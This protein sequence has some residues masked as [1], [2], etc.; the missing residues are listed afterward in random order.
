[1][2][3][4]LV[5]YEEVI[6]QLAGDSL[7]CFTSTG[8]NGCRFRPGSYS[9]LALLHIKVVTFKLLSIQLHLNMPQL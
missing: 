2:I 6:T 1:M 8:I 9:Q 5:S 7:A 4:E 3:T